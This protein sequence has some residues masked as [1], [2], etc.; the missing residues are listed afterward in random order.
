M[1]AISV[2]SLK[3]AYGSVK[4]VDDISF[5][6]DQGEVFSLLG[7]NGAGKTTTI[8]ILEGLREK[9]AGSARVPVGDDTDMMRRLFEANKRVVYA[10]EAVVYHKVSSERLRM[11]YVRRR[12]FYGGLAT[13]LLSTPPSSSA[14]RW[15]V[16]EC[17]ERTFSEGLSGLWAY[18]RGQQAVGMEREIRCWFQLGQLSGALKTYLR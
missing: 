7:P 15:F 14:P 1:S 3:K 18:G 6:I 2:D 12:M 11:A 16:R 13:V 17:L 10:P 5:A 4:A 8:E 9:D